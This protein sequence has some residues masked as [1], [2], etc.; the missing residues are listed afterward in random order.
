VSIA[1]R[2]HAPIVSASFKQGMTIEISISRGA[3]KGS[4]S[5]NALDNRELS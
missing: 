1:F 3:A 4:V 5:R 2:T